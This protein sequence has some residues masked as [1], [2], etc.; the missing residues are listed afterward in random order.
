[1]VGS[2]SPG[3]NC[4]DFTLCNDSYNDSYTDSFSGSL[5][6]IWTHEGDTNTAS[7][8]VSGELEHS[9]AGPPAN[10]RRVTYL[11][12][13]P[14]DTVDSLE[15][16]VD[17]DSNGTGSETQF[18]DVFLTFDDTTNY[19]INGRH[20][21]LNAFQF[22][23]ALNVYRYF[24]NGSWNLTTAIPADGDTLKIT[25]NKGTTNWDVDFLVNG[26]SIVTMGPITNV[27][28]H[29]DDSTD[30]CGNIIKLESFDQTSANEFYFDNFDAAF[31]Y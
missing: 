29:D 21:S 19:A 2:L 30:W 20:L 3:C 27:V 15:I 8:I 23:K 10:G 9:S 18:W 22:G 24:V 4:C 28:I 5:N 16:E 7:A 17:I 1:M 12:L 6:A 26:T 14:D 13:S 11:R 31:A 25:I